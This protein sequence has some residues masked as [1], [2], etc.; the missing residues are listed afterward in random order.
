MDADRTNRV[1][2]LMQ[3]EL[4]RLF[5]KFESTGLPARAEMV[6]EWNAMVDRI[7]ERSREFLTDAQ[8]SALAAKLK[9]CWSR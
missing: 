1:T 7:G 5:H 8:R 6:S 2:A 3:D 9:D 4:E